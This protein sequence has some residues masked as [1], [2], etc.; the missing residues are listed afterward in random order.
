MS[1]PKVTIIVRSY[2][3][4]KYIG[5]T[6]EMIRKQSFQ[7][8]EVL[9][10][11]SGSTDG[12]FECVKSFSPELSYQI[13]PGEYIP[14]KVLNEAVKKA[15]GEIIVFNNSDCIPQNDKWLAE[16]VKPFSDDSVAAVYGNQVTRPDARPLV[17]KDGIR[18]FGDGSISA[19]WEHFFSLATSAIPKNLLLEYPFNPD[20]QYSEDVEWSY[21]MK[22]LEYKIV[23][24]PEAIVEHSHNYTLAEVKKRFFNEG[25]AEGE[26]Y[27]S[28]VGFIAGFLKPYLVETVRDSLYLCRNMYLLEI[29]YGL[30]YRMAQKFY[31]YKGRCRYF[32]G[33]QSRKEGT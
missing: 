31:I 28:E 26:I 3:D 17:V 13:K 14:G 29:P 5:Q 16:L 7:D 20:I 9:N 30:V 4:I 32:K 6:M 10:V 19:T 11:D 2:N 8:F 22:K 24:S 12:T 27:Q 21:R 1:N 18:A 33:Q 15:T 25:L 23:Y